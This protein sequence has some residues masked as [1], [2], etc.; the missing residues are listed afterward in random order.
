MNTESQTAAQRSPNGTGL[1]LLGLL[2]LIFGPFTAVPGI[3][4]SGKFRPFSG[5]AVTGYFLCWFSLVMSLI[6]VLLYVS[7]H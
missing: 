2:S 5:A 7:I 1:L 4:I 6:V 3:F